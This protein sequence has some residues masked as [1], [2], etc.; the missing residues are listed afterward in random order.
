MI[1]YLKMMT[2]L[3]LLLA[4][5]TSSQAADAPKKVPTPPPAAAE[6]DNEV[7]ARRI[8]KNGNDER[9]LEVIPMEKGCVLQ[10][11]KAGKAEEKAKAS[12][13][14]QV[15]QDSLQKIASR[16]EAANFHCE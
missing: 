11:T 7:V 3:F 14:V 9:I 16:L 10:Y 12:H 6:A 13:G 2:A 4:L 5:S 8:C 1:E 15:C